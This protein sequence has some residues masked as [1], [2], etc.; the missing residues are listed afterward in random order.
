MRLYLA[1]MASAALLVC[2]CDDDDV[3]DETYPDIITEMVDV[4]TN[5]NGRMTHLVTDDGKSYA[6][7][8]DLTGYLSSVIYRTICGFVPSGGN[9]TVYQMKGVYLLGD[10]TAVAATDP[11]AV[12]CAWRAGRYINMQLAPLSQGGTQ[13]WGYAVG[14]R[15]E[16]HLHITLHHRQNFDPASYTVDTYASIV[17]DKLGLADGDTI[18]LHVNT[19][20]G[21]KEWNFRK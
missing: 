3:Y 1:L 16:G 20:T 12:V 7:L 9:A 13:W 19:P 11:V 10:S 17:V 8:N 14:E 4:E 5:A 21:E 15:T 2:S 18:T 6:I